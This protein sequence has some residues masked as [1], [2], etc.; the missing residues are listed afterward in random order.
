MSSVTGILMVIGLG[1]VIGVVLGCSMLAL[2][3]VFVKR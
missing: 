2:V 3:I 1:V